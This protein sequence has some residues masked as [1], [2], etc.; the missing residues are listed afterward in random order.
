VG[1]KATIAD[2][3]PATQPCASIPFLFRS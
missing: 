3:Q 2:I 1:V